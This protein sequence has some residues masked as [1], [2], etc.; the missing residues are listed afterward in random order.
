MDRDP[1]AIELEDLLFVTYD[2]NTIDQEQLLEAIEE[3]GFESQV[4]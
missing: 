3:E 1:E 2:V 4:R